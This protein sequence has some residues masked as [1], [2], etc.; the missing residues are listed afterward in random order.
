M[1]KL[2]I[3]RKIRVFLLV[4]TYSRDFRKLFIYVDLIEIKYLPQLPNGTFVTV[5]LY[6]FS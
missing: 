6:F 1:Q 4:A 3:K 5:V 2:H